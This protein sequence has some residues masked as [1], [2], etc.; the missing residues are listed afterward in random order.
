MKRKD[1][2]AV[3]EDRYMTTPR[4]VKVHIM[5]F[6]NVSFYCNYLLFKK[7]FICWENNVVND[8]KYYLH[9]YNISPSVT[10]I[11]VTISNLK[12]YSGFAI[13]YIATP[14]RMLHQNG[15]NRQRIIKHVEFSAVLCKRIKLCH[16][17]FKYFKTVNTILYNISNYIFKY[18]SIS[19]LW[20]NMTLY[21]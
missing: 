4:R 17:M 10:C 5:I 9:N 20:Y 2:I 12:Q 16:T 11:I 8:D 21:K 15:Q 19:T 6:I 18:R 7:V 1:H 3:F 13:G 14:L